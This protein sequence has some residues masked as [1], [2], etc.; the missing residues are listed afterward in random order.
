MVLQ[1]C[2]NA[3]VA[4]FPV[5]TQ[6]RCSTSTFRGTAGAAGLTRTEGAGPAGRV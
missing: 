1:P 2:F 6:A 3:A 5:E 4:G